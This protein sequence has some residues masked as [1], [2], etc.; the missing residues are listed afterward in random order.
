MEY[1]TSMRYKDYKLEDF[2]MDE[3]FIQWVKFPDRNNCH[4]WEKWLQ[5]H[6]Q[7]RETV[8]QAV[9]L[10][11]GVH[12]GKNELF[13]DTMYVETFENIIRTTNSIGSK[14]RVERDF[15]QIFDFFSVRKF[16]AIMVLGFCCWMSYSLMFQREEVKEVFVEI[17]M[18]KKINPAGIKSLITLSDGSKVYLN[19]GSSIQFPKQF[20][21][22][23]R[24]VQLTGE[25]FFD[26]QSEADRPFV[27]NT[28][29]T[30]I[31]VLGTTFNVNQEESGKIAVALVS[32]KVR[33]N[34]D[35]G[36]QVNLDPSEML[37][38]EHSGEFYKTGFDPLEILGW[39][40]KQLVFKKDAFTVVQR[41]LE[42]WYGVEVQV[43][44][45]MPKNWVY[46]GVYRD[47]LLENVLA[48]IFYTSGITYKIEGKKITIYN[49]K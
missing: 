32:G 30:Q 42:N 5:E 48:G 28:A 43:K 15:F 9:Q 8:M 40:D 41:K 13:T 49:P 20:S 10:I 17:P 47:E 7:K 36:N 22:D 14:M 31:K 35:K 18:V 25:A 19:A 38:M 3:F 2:L 24:E 46:T 1:P 6:P 34:D 37:V 23:R 4:F 44:G 33:V 11:R 29:N 21:A 39:K 27:V 16:V 12:Y 45:R 26:I